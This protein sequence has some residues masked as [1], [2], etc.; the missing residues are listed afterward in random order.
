[1]LFSSC[2]VKSLHPF[3]TKDA[4]A[5]NENLIGHWVDNKK[6]KW[7]LE[8]FVDAFEKDR[9]KGQK[10]SKEDEV[11]Y[12]N[13][14]KA[15][16]ANYTKKEKEAQFIV[17]PFKVD[18]QYFLDFIP[19]VYDDNEINSLAAQHLLKT[20]SVAKLDMESD[21]DASLSWLSEE[22]ISNLL[23]QKKMAE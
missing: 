15:Y 23:N 11:M 2:I 14:K 8:S 16:V 17:M 13:Y 7:Q 1:M 20:H 21:N 4:V 22:R 19:I 10:L 9:K 12:E 18:N 5:F 3:Y 6:G